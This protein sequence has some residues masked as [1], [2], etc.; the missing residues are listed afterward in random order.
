M[1]NATR[2]ALFLVC[3]SFAY[4]GCTPEETPVTEVQAPTPTQTVPPTI[5][6]FSPQS[7]FAG[8]QVTILG[9]GFGQLPI[10]IQVFF[11]DVEAQVVSASSTKIVVVVP[12][13]APDKK[14]QVKAEGGQA[15]TDEAFT[16]FD[17][18]IY[19]V[20]NVTSGGSR[21]WKNNILQEPF[22][23]SFNMVHNGIQIEN[24]DVYILGTRGISS[25]NGQ[26]RAWKNQD[27][28]QI[29]LDLFS[30]SS[31]RDIFVED[32]GEVSIV[33]FVNLNGNERGALWQGKETLPVSYVDGSVFNAVTKNSGLTFIVG[34][35]NFNP[36]IW[37]DSNEFPLPIEG[38]NF[39]SA[40]DITIVNN[41]EYIVG[42]VGDTPALAR[43]AIWI[44]RQLSFLPFPDGLDDFQIT[45]V[46]V[47]GDGNYY[48][49]GNSREN[50]VRNAVIWRNGVFSFIDK[51]DVTQNSAFDVAIFQGNTYVVGT[52]GGQAV[53]WKNGEPTYLG[54][55]IARSIFIVEK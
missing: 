43:P 12:E 36:S 6:S 51:S 5:E 41:T 9:T 34:D 50:G 30:R 45:T 49:V 54:G 47:D 28:L 44:N 55:G 27:P 1:K 26:I 42:I 3:I 19:I 21:T 16:V 40:V 29:D 10:G 20:G 52:I 8:E 48:V 25:T 14:I 39:G 32:N 37:V 33:G 46:T 15:F 53:V 18:D 7:A 35:N 31:S 22:D 13:G 23:S 38:N 2:A 4:L 24:D 17:Y 11:G